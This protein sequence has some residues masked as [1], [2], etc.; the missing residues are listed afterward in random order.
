MVH[1]NFV[2]LSLLLVCWAGLSI[3]QS[4][5]RGE[6]F[7]ESVHALLQASYS[8]FN[9]IKR[10]VARHNDGSTDWVPSIT[11]AGTADCEGQSDPEIPS[12]VSCTGAVS[13]SQDELEPIYQ[14]AVKQLRTCLDRSFVYEETHGGKE[15]RLST[16]IKEATFEIK[17]KDEGPDGPA[18]RIT[19]DQYHSTHRTEYEITIWVDAKGKE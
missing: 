3:T 5:P 12:S 7:C 17:A 9:G 18:V 4:Q 11:V 8:D 14:N 2:S 10:N 16:P 15:T 1:R 6:A 13:Q 19:F